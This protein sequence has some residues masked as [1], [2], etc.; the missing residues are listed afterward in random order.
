MF[1]HRPVKWFQWPIVR[2]G[3]ERNN[4]Q[5]SEHIKDSINEG[6]KDYNKLYTNKNCLNNLG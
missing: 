6:E 3:S 2:R 5:H 4:I 1:E